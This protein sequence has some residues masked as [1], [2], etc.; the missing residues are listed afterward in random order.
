MDATHLHLVVNHLPIVGTFL[1]L[2]LL[3]LAL[4]RRADAGALHAAALVLVLAGGG[5]VVAKESGQRAEEA[6]EHL[7]GTD[8][9]ALQTHEERAEV[10][11][12]LSVVTALLALGTVAARAWRPG[13]AST[14]ATVVTLAAAAGSAGA[15][16]WVGQS[17]GLIRHSELR[18][19]APQAPGEG[20]V[21]EREGD[22]DND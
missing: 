14:V 8:E 11:V 12:P 1:A 9:A 10:A 13:V 15:M 7:V 17:G 4:V 19:G 6:V 16:A 22:G 5:A 20:L 2:P 18:D 21:G 3:L